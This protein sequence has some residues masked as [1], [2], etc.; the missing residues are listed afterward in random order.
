MAGGA[1]RLL[2]QARSST[3]GGVGGGAV[4]S[5]AA[6]AASTVGSAAAAGATLAPISWSSRL[7]CSWA[8]AGRFVFSLPRQ[9]QNLTANQHVARPAWSR[10]RSI[11]DQ[12]GAVGWRVSPP[13]TPSSSIAEMT[14]CQARTTMA[15]AM[16]MVR[17]SALTPSLLSSSFCRSSSFL[18]SS[19]TARDVALKTAAR[20]G[21]R[22]GILSV[23]SRRGGG[24]GGGGEGGG[25]RGGWV[26]E[27][28]LSKGRGG[29]MSALSMPLRRVA[30]SFTSSSSSSS[31]SSLTS[32]IAVMGALRGAT[33]A[34]IHAGSHSASVAAAGEATAGMKVMQAM[35]QGSFAELS[36]H[37][38]RC[39][40]ELSKARLSLLVVTTAGA[41]YV[42]ASGEVI[43]WSGLMWTSIGT[44]MAA[45]SANAFNQAMEVVNDASMKRTM[46][47]P[48]PSGRIG[49]GHAIAFATLMGL[50]GVGVL[51]WKTDG[52]TAAM[53]AGN[54]ALYTLVYT[55]LK[56]L[57]V[58]NT[59]VGAVVGGIP[60][61]MGWS[62]AKG[63]GGELDWSSAAVLAAALYLWQIPHFMAL[64]WLCRAD[65]A[66]GGY[67][68]M[69]LVDKTGRRTAG[70]ALRNALYLLP[71]GY[72]A[73]EL[74]LTSNWFVYE[75]ALLAGWLIGSALSFYKVPT[76][77]TARGLFRASLVYL[78]ALM[79]AMIVHRVP[80]RNTAAALVT[81]VEEEKVD[82]LLLIDEEE[83][84]AMEKI[85]KIVMG[86]G[87][88]LRDVVGI[89]RIRPSMRRDDQVRALIHGNTAT[90]GE[91]DGDGG[92]SSSSSR[93]DWRMSNRGDGDRWEEEVKL[94]PPPIAHVL[95]APFPFLP[96][97]HFGL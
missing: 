39:Y 43:D 38:G 89:H 79:T 46:R 14:G 64:A 66:R 91:I 74:G 10:A 7:A 8:N 80:Q 20:V 22:G 17:R 49:M 75:N 65:Y 92:S 44:M 27:G 36:R 83:S 35:K 61:L 32:A 21:G 94:P 4:A 47:R 5:A 50:A 34:A 45:S 51:A 11:A 52:L 77:T 24:S 53:G 12:E 42:M 88:G 15:M 82:G 54:I 3:R 26:G 62:A 93:S 96:A 60:P 19:S 41:G 84:T 73:M 25:G 33:S 18:P 48:L 63:G 95:V 31:S 68:M 59:W 86:L 97:P 56:Q 37:Y 23:G 76:P 55:P 6:S 70:A 85:R 72:V 30:T 28:S 57:H 78:P 71:L 1:V 58:C 29:V 69:S 16:A 90:V 2:R 67:K 13:P 87:F 9:Q 81:T 40:Y